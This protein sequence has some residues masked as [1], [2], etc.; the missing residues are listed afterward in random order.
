MTIQFLVSSSQA[1]DVILYVDYYF[2]LYCDYIYLYHFFYCTDA[3]IIVD[4]FIVSIL[5][6]DRDET[7]STSIN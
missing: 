4:Q 7:L 5:L 3:Q 6:Y 2:C 1:K